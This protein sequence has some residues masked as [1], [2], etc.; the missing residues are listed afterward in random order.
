M[1]M[2]TAGAMCS[3]NELFG[4]DSFHGAFIEGLET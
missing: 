3:N 4:R 2:Y 1:I